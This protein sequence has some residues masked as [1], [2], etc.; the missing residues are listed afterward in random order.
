MAKEMSMSNHSGGHLYT[1]TNETGNAVIHYQWSA[2][3]ALTEM[4]RV[5]TG[6]AGSGTFKPLF[7]NLFV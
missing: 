3:G 2:S 5:P 6:G 4:E 7:G 1:Q